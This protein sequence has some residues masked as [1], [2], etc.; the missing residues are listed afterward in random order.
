M[1]ADAASGEEIDD[2][3]EE[4]LIG[5]FHVGNYGNFLTLCAALEKSSGGSWVLYGDKKVIMFWRMA[6]GVRRPYDH[7]IWLKMLLIV[8]DAFHPMVGGVVAGESLKASLQCAS[9]VLYTAQ[10]MLHAVS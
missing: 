5:V 2:V 8:I 1:L 3:H 6:S 7:I 10:Y 4:L 9:S